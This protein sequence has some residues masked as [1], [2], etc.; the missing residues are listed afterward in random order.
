[1][2]GSGTLHRRDC[3]RKDFKEEKRFS[4][5]GGG[6]VYFAPPMEA[7]AA[8]HCCSEAALWRHSFPIPW[9]ITGAFFSL[10]QDQ[11]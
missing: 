1:M 8:S 9:D 10:P 7:G 6:E 4:Q 3:L 11:G 2:G 5:L